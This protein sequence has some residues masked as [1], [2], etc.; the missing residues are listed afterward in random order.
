MV[1]ASSDVAVSREEKRDD[2]EEVA[3]ASPVE[4]F[5]PGLALELGQVTAHWSQMLNWVGQQD[6]NLP[7]LLTMSKPLAIEGTT[8]VL[9]FDFPIFREKF[10]QQTTHAHLIQQA[11]EQ[12]IGVKCQ[13]KAVVSS[14]YVPN[15]SR[16]D[17]ENLADEL[18]GVV[19]ED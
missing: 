2:K 14:Q 8:L 12:L 18:G 16:Q 15:V 10:D 13:I 5:E 1:E 4:A 7:A 19:H 11:L 3:E 17:L 6:R 9:G